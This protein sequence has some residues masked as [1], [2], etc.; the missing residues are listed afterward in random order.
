[1]S[2]EGLIAV[3]PM[4]DFPWTAAA[5]DALW[6]S[7]SARLSAADVRAPMRLT[8][9]GDLAAQWRDPRLVFGQTCGY[10]NVTGLKDAVTPIATPD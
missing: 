7:I 2:G 4:Y 3:L 5:N 6:A 1:M 9:V 10:P 8:R